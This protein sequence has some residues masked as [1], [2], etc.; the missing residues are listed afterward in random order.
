MFGV[1]VRGVISVLVR[2]TVQKFLCPKTLYKVPA[3]DSLIHTPFSFPFN[4]FSLLKITAP[5]LPSLLSFLKI[6]PLKIAW[7][8]RFLS[9]YFSL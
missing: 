1:F 9:I 2:N 6:K 5:H 4:F 7:L 3:L 8:F